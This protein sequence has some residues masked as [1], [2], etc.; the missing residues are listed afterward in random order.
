MC[1]YAYHTYK[2]HYACFD[3]R[4]TFKRRLMSDLGEAKDESAEATCPNCAKPMANMG[5]DF[6]APVKK[7]E[8]AWQHLKKL[9]SV[10][11]AFHSC[12]C[13]GPGRKPTD[14]EEIA[15]ELLTQKER[16]VQHLRFWLNKSDPT[17]KRALE[18]DRQRNYVQYGFLYH[19]QGKKGGVQARQAVAYWTEQV[20]E[21]EHKLGKVL[22]GIA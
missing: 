6:A 12:G 17:T 1:R 8:K 13:G 16:Y 14:S 9:Y 3:C 20:H 7:D 22:V 5:L 2:S 19:L 18:Q 21:V 15:T 11:I 10:G 4:K